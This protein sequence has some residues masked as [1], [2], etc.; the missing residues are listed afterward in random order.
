MVVDANGII[1]TTYGGV[2]CDVSTSWAAEWLGKMAAVRLAL[3]VG[4]PPQQLQLS[5][6]DNLAASLAPD[7]GRPSRCAWL[8]RIRIAF[9]AITAPTP[10][11]EAYT[12]ATHDTGWSHT[13]ASWQAQCDTLA[14]KGTNAAHPFNQGRLGD[15]TA[16]SL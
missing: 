5:I 14:E 3:A 10:L 16:S 8:D 4:V 6:A 11:R 9:A 1:A 12:P 2:I 15:T 13:A 7:G